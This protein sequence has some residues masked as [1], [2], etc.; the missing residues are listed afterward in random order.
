[1][2]DWIYKPLKNDIKECPKCK[3]WS[4]SQFLSLCMI[5]KLGMK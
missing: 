4:Y 5:Y 3:N 1:M 2:K